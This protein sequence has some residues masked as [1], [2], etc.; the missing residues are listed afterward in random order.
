MR[1]RAQGRWSWLQAL[2]LLPL[3]ALSTPAPTETAGSAPA[4]EVVVPKQLPRGSDGEDA[5]LVILLSVFGRSFEL[6]LKPDSSF[7]APGLK[8]ERIG[9]SLGEA[10]VELEPRGCFYSGTV[11]REAESLAAVSVCHGLSGSFVLPGE[12]FTV[13]PL[14]PDSGASINQPHLVQRWGR[15][16]DTRGA[17]GERVGEHQ[18]AAKTEGP[19]RIAH[20]R[21]TRRKKRFVNEPLYLEMMLVADETLANFYGASLQVR[22]KG[23]GRSH[24]PPQSRPSE[25]T[26]W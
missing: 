11:H 13:Q 5:G 8:V 19:G 10:E 15:T 18:G 21:V 14:D 23:L 2:L 16:A 24:R 4:W 20:P 3:L 1:P 12:E 25:H 26:P 9:G 22:R 7:L 17:A 6:R